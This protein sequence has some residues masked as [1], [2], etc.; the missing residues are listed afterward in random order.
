M[1]ADFMR[2]ES[3]MFA[4][5]IISRAENRWFLVEAWKK[6]LQACDGVVGV[7]LHVSMADPSRDGFDA[8]LINA[9]D[10]ILVKLCVRILVPVGVLSARK[11]QR[12]GNRVLEQRDIKGDSC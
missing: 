4:H 2:S 11:K 8:V 1:F 10:E 12:R 9:I 6:S 5:E 7:K 3:P